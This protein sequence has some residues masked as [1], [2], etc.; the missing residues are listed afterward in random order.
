MV[1]FKA[2]LLEKAEIHNIV[3]H[4]YNTNLIKMLQ[5]QSKG[6]IFYQQSLDRAEVMGK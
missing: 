1:Q 2:L 4:S 5:G 6:K 3:S